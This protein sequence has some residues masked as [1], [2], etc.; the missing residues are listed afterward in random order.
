MIPGECEGTH[1][2]ACALIVFAIGL[3][4]VWRVHVSK[5]IGKSSL[6]QVGTMTGL[7][8]RVLLKE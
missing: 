2:A 3:A 4:S 8:Y 6:I 5:Y 1:S 7:G